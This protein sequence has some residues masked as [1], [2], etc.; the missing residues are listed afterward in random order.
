MRLIKIT[1]GFTMIVG[2]VGLTTQ[3]R[4]HIQMAM[5]SYDVMKHL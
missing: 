1:F 3:L 2:S 5:N 4:N